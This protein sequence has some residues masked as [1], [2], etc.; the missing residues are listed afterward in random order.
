[1]INNA[2][3]TQL[4]TD[5]FN[6]E[7]NLF[8][9]KEGVFVGDKLVPASETLLAF[10]DMTIGDAIRYSDHIDEN[11]VKFTAACEAFKETP[12]MANWNKYREH[13]KHLYAALWLS[14]FWRMFMKEQ[15]ST[16]ANKKGI[17]E[18]HYGQILAN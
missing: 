6:N 10:K 17:S 1:M 2:R 7:F 16:C 11:C 15:S 18:L 4:K 5:T 3:M 14:F 9:V 12:S 13:H 8:S